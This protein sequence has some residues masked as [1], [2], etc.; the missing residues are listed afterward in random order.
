MFKELYSLKS[1]DALVQVYK[2]FEMIN[3]DKIVI[4]MSSIISYFMNYDWSK[5]VH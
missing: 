5:V 4:V 2:S 1:H 3:G